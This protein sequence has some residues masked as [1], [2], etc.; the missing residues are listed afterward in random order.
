[1]KS[2]AALSQTNC[3]VARSPWLTGT[4]NRDV[5][6]L[7]SFVITRNKQAIKNNWK[8]GNSFRAT[9]KMRMMPGFF[10]FQGDYCTPVGGCFFATEQTSFLLFV[11]GNRNTFGV[12]RV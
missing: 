11:T 8:K 4:N 3:I 9:L 7:P 12:M 5:A 1:V 2:R 10:R 6:T